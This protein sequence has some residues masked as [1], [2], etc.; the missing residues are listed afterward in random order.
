MR[1]YSST[2]SLYNPLSSPINSLFADV[3]VAISEPTKGRPD[4]GELHQLSSSIYQASGCHVLASFLACLPLLRHDDLP[5]KEICRS[6]PTQPQHIS[7]IHK[8]RA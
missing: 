7:V 3:L 1:A 4:K 8:A 5:P 2:Q 6:R